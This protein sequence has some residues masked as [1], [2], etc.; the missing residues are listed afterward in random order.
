MNLVNARGGEVA[1]PLYLWWL[2]DPARPVH[3][4]ELLPVHNGQ[5]VSLRYARHWLRQGFALSE[6]LPLRRA[7]FMPERGRAAGAVQ[8]ARPERWGERVVQSLDRPRRL[9]ILEYL[10]FAGHERFGAMVVS[11]S[12]NAYVPLKPLAAFAGPAAVALILEAVRLVEA[13]ETVPAALRDL[14]APG[15]GLGGT[16]PKTLIELDGQQWVLKFAEHGEDLDAPLIEHATLTLAQKA[17]IRVA[18]TVVVPL[19]ARRG[20]AIGVQRFDRELHAGKTLRRRAPAGNA[21]AQMAELF[22]RMVFNLFMD[23][24][25]DHEKNHAL[26]LTDAGEFELSPA[27]DV[28]PAAQSLGYQQMRVGTAGSES[29]LDNALSMAH[30]F[31]LGPAEAR[32]QAARV[33]AVVQ[34][35]RTHFKKLGVPAREI[36]ALTAHIDREALRSQRR[37]A[38]AAA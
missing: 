2:R 36:D 6:D 33:A 34:R 14:V 12:A 13:G 32:A 5:G 24:T 17:G 25:D 10:L 18:S 31:G 3:V 29:T 35:W 27:Y 28:L 15:A 26:L 7:A 23:N 19:G 21:A 8:D 4:G 1:S 11:E 16:K 38:L 20:H 37:L 30:Q 9:S 22:R